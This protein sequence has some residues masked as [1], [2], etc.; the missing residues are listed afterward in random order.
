MNV[1]TSTIK[2]MVLNEIETLSDEM[3]APTLRAI[4]SLKNESLN[5]INTAQESFGSE[6]TLS[7]AAAA[8][9]KLADLWNL[10]EEDDAW[11]H[12]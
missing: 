2:S 8:N 1:T 6:Y 5:F 3:L 12:L 11:Q 10:P 4:R 7:M 9:C